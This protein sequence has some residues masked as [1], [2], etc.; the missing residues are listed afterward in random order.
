NNS[1][2]LIKTII[3]SD[4]YF[5]IDR[6]LSKGPCSTVSKVGGVFCAN[7]IVPKRLDWKGGQHAQT[8]D[9]WTRR[10]SDVSDNQLLILCKHISSMLDSNFSKHCPQPETSLLQSGRNLRKISRDITWSILHNI[11]MIN[12]RPMYPPHNFG[13]KQNWLNAV[14]SREFGCRRLK[15]LIC[16]VQPVYG[17][18]SMCLRVL[19][20]LSSVYC[21]LFDRTGT[22]IF[23][24]S[25]DS[26]IKCWC[27]WSGRLLFTFRGHQAEI[28]DMDISFDN[29]LLATGSCNKEIRVWNIQNA[30]PVAVL[31]GHSGMLTS[32]EFSPVTEGG[33][34]YLISTGRD[35][36][37]C[38]WR[39]NLHNMEFSK[40]PVKFQE[41]SRPGVSIMCASWSAG[42]RFAVAAGSDSI[43][44]VYSILPASAEPL[45]LCELA[46]HTDKV[47]SIWFAHHGLKFASSSY[48]GTAIIWNYV[49]SEWKPLILKEKRESDS[50]EV[51][52]LSSKVRVIMV[53]WTYNDELIMTSH[54]DFTIRVWKSSTAKLLT[55]LK[56]HEDEAY[57]LE[58]H[59][60]DWR[61]FL[62]AGHDGNIFL[63]DITT[64][65]RIINFHNLLVGQGHGAVFDAKFSPTGDHIACTDSHGHLIL[66]GYGD[67]SVYKKVPEEQ[68]F[69][70]DYRPLLHDSFGGV[71]DE[72]TQQAPNRMPPPFLV[73]VDG[74]PH[75]PAFQR[76]VPGRQQLS[77]DSL[78][79][80]VVAADNGVPLIMNEQPSSRQSP[81]ANNNGNYIDIFKAFS[82]DAPEIQSPST[83]R[84]TPLGLRRE[85]ELVGVRSMSS[86]QS[87]IA[88]EADI[89]AFQQRQL[90]PLLKPA[91]KMKREEL[92]R[93]TGDVEIAIYNEEKSRK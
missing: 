48:D 4:L 92:A 52:P 83:L 77:N 53:A 3:F 93:A 74:N 89:I 27:A 79:P 72:Q 61:V 36:N 32:I 67:G 19:G 80:M 45:K 46:S 15:Q 81:P 71:L 6:F 29:S 68:F 20:H 12:G 9:E 23:T 21:I 51:I 86:P 40:Q 55:T 17:K 44:H 10:F 69:H 73:D 63:W 50:N 62:S 18:M 33:R 28:C 38:F 31:Q 8:Y 64:G 76:L 41:R 2:S 39:W 25:D 70:T 42:G 5:L 65:D 57:C 58:A 60:S 37:V 84:N 66:F 14:K 7:S 47:D 82:S 85:G 24:G 78:I 54:S 49:G 22:R 16:P 11:A 30:E 35:G 1:D 13:K 87:Y 26:L 34:G 59:P 90:V 91:V 75:P 56:G 88:S 43:I